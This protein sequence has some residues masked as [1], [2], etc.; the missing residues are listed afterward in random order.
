MSSGMKEQWY[1]DRFW[2]KSE[3]AMSA[4]T[5][6]HIKTLIS[7]NKSSA[8]YQ[9]AFKEIQKEYDEGRKR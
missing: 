9:Q 5:R 4:F 6:K 8:E 7:T 3:P 2:G 1:E